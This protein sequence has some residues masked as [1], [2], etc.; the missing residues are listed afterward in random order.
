MI[1]RVFVDSNILIYSQ[2][3]SVGAKQLTA[4][5]WLLHLWTGRIGRVS[6]QVLNEFYYSVTQKLKPGLSREAA[7]KKV[8]DLFAWKPLHVDTKMLSS[9]WEIQD[10]YSLS[11]WDS[12]IVSAA[13][14]AGCKFL[15][16]EDLSDGQTIWGVKIL[17][18]F[19]HSPP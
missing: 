5:D 9:S 14:H 12:L 19:K 10:R 2:D 18:P 13:H 15:L 3:A 1:E 8:R 4:R 17:D 7:R 16:T 6:T 11:F